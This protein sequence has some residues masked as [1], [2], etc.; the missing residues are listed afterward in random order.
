MYN[1]IYL[2]YMFAVAS[3]LS[4]CQDY[5]IDI[6]RKT[7]AEL[8]ACVLSPQLGMNKS[9]FVNDITTAAHKSVQVVD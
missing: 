2:Q 4:D 1:A 9:S 6:F 7:T 8:S 5:C 3:L